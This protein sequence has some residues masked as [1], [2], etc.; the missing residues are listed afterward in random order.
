M[1]DPRLS[2][3]IRRKRWFC[4]GTKPDE[5]GH[6]CLAGTM[7]DAT[8]ITVVFSVFMIYSNYDVIE[9]WFVLPS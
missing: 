7:N 8:T 9:R 2:G 1:V 6:K 3:W 4:P 5:M